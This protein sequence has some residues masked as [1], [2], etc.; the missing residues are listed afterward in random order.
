MKLVK[1]GSQLP[2][3]NLDFETVEKQQNKRKHGSLLPNSIRCI[4][5]GPSNCGKTNLMLS[6]ITNPNGLC[7]ENIYLYSK[8]L[9]QPKYEFLRKV[10]EKIPFIGYFAYNENADII[11]P[12]AAKQNSVFIFDDVACDKQDKMRAYFSMGRHNGVDCFYLCQSYSRIPKQLIR[13]NA[14]LI[15]VYQQDDLNLRHIY[16]DHVT[17]DMT[18]QKFKELCRECWKDKYGFVVINKD[19]AIPEGRYC[20]A[21]DYYIY[22]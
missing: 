7:F 16:E 4:I 6:L 19:N 20:K 13:D 9:L 5:V 21:F 10:L 22:P 8:S 15:M 2:V 11:D 17:T 14:N 1:V 3:N 18:F 12:S